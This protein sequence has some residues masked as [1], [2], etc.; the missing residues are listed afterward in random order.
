MCNVDS[1]HGADFIQFTVSPLP[2]SSSSHLPLFNEWC[3]ASFV[4]SDDTRVC[5]LSLL[6]SH[7]G[8]VEPLW[9]D[10]RCEASQQVSDN[11]GRR[12]RSL[13]DSPPPTSSRFASQST[14]MNLCLI[15]TF[16]EQMKTWELEIYFLLESWYNNH[17][18]TYKKQSL[19]ALVQPG[20][21]WEYNPLHNTT[22]QHTTAIGL[23]EGSRFIE[24]DTSRVCV[25]CWI[26]AP[27]AGRWWSSAGAP[28]GPW[29]RRARRAPASASLPG[30]AG[31]CT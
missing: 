21:T 7:L 19:S 20:A 13:A 1:L 29:R 4:S 31:R 18:V 6:L 3:S 25:A 28:E 15:N 26:S 5:R 24:S 9:E 17:T 2:L 22:L 10:W 8:P 23:W 12:S 14:D 30:P 16:K 11:T 27:A